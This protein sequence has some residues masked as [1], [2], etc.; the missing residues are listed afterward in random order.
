M[1]SRLGIDV[2][3]T[4]TDLLLFN[5]GTGEL[6]LVKTP[7]TPEDQ[8]VGILTGIQRMIDEAGVQPSDIQG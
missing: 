6:H 5:D 8:S 1:S 7:S 4:F 2:G 3:G